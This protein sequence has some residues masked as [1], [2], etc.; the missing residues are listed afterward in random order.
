MLNDRAAV[1]SLYRD[2]KILLF[3]TYFCNSAALYKFYQAFNVFNI[4]C[5][6][7]YSFDFNWWFFPLHAAMI[8]TSERNAEAVLK[9][10]PKAN[11]K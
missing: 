11:F 2:L 1:D 8:N 4:H 6:I 10:K 3:E 7:I 9:I 5:S